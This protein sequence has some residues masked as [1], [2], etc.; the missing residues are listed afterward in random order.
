MWKYIKL[1]VQVAHPFMACRRAAKK[2]LKKGTPDKKEFYFICQKR[3]RQ[4]FKR[5]LSIDFDI[6]GMENIPEKANFLLVSNHQ[7]NLD[8][9]IL[10]G[11]MPRPISFVTKKENMNLP[12]IPPIIE[13]LGSV[14]LDRENLKQEVKAIMQVEKMLQSDPEATFAIYPEGTRSR[15]SEHRVAPFKPGSLK[16]AF[17][18]DCPILPVA[19][20]GS[21]RTLD[22]KFR[23]THYPVQIHFLKP[24]DPSEFSIHSTVEVAEEVERRVREEVDKEREQDKLLMEKNRKYIRTK[25]LPILFRGV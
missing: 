11:L 19:V 4:A 14:P 24:V 15:D 2:C 18:A 6:Q 23:M 20:F 13:A 17:R 8:P 9:I 22:K 21:F 1:G 5:G 25:K 12:L 3:I 16:P 10:C 7:S